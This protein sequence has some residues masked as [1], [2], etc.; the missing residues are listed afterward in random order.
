MLPGER[1]CVCVCRGSQGCVF[2]LA[3][4][5]ELRIKAGTIPGET[6]QQ[7]CER[8]RER[9]GGGNG[10]KI[11]KRTSKCAPEKEGGKNNAE[12]ASV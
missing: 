4:V 12:Q 8:W 1:V 2:V 9:N 11:R 10:D 5:S 3:M 7:Y 6:S